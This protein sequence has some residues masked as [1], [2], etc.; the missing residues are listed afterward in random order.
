[1][2]IHEERCICRCQLVGSH[3]YY[4]YEDGWHKSEVKRDSGGLVSLNGLFAIK[5]EDGEFL[6]DLDRINYG[7][8]KH[9]F[10]I[11]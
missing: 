6:C 3:I 4:R 11:K 2:T 1:M 10:M 5:Y 8:K 9:F 7:A